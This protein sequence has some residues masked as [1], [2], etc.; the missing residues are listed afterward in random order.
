MYLNNFSATFSVNDK[1]ELEDF[2]ED[3][4]FCLNN[5]TCKSELEGATCEC[6]EGYMG[7]RC[8]WDI[9]DCADEPC[10]EGDCVDQV[11]GYTCDCNHGYTGVW[12]YTQKRIYHSDFEVI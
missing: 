1:C 3:K 4:D 5:S 2:C 6:L 7:E 10:V 12:H 11:N 8:Q 9:D